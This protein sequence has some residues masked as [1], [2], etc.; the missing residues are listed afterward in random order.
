ML[1]NMEKEHCKVNTKLFYPYDFYKENYQFPKTRN[2]ISNQG[3]VRNQER[4][5][6]WT[7]I[8]N[9]IILGDLT[10]FKVSSDENPLIEDGYQLIESLFGKEIFH[11][12][13]KI[14]ELAIICHDM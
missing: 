10:V 4:W 9:N 8:S 11:K 6:L 5:S 3:W 1:W 12:E 13:S 7:I 14:I 2:D